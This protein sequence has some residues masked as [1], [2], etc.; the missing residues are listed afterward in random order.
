MTKQKKLGICA[1]CTKL[2]RLCDSHILPRWLYRERGTNFKLIS[3]THPFK[4]R[5]PIGPYEKL[6]CLEC[7]GL[8][9]RYD[10]Y[11]AE[12]FK[13]SRYWPCDERTNWR[14]VYTY[15]YE[16]LK[17][18]FL[19]VLWRAGAANQDFYSQI[20]PDAA[21]MADLHN[22]IKNGQPGDAQDYSVMLSMRERHNGLEKVGWNPCIT[23]KLDKLQWAHFDLNEFSCDIKIGK[24]L[25]SFEPRILLSDV[26][27]VLIVTGPTFNERISQFRNHSLN[28][29]ERERQF[30]ELHKKKKIQVDDT[31]PEPQ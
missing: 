7:E 30:R 26:P 18:F 17:L 22:M 12:F 11:S 14:V 13:V 21:T 20:Q 31:N 5:R 10:E 29:Q 2:R 3:S 8:M 16:K 27:P 9:G 24:E 1:F 23:T 25:T 4:L 19:S 28:Q 6:L 15:D